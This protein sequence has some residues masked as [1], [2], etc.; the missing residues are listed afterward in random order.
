MRLTGLATT[1]TNRLISQREAT[2]KMVVKDT[3]DRKQRERKE[4][5]HKRY[6]GQSHVMGGAM[7]L[8]W[9]EKAPIK[10]RHKRPFSEGYLPETY[11]EL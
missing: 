8:A 6:A 10:R 11:V 5:S 3:R 9:R 7:L 4:L 1:V 2:S